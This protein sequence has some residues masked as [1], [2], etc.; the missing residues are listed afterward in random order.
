MNKELLKE[1]FHFTKNG[2]ETIIIGIILV[3]QLIIYT[4]SYPFIMKEIVDKAIPEGNMKIVVILSFILIAIIL[5]RFITNSYT[6]VRRKSC[7]YNNDNEIKEKLFKNIQESKISKIEQLQIGKLFEVV[8]NQSYEASQLFVWNFVGIISVRLALTIAISI[9]LLLLNMKLGLIVIS[10]F[11]LSYCILIPIY[12]KTMKV[13]KKLQSM[14]I[15]LQASVNEYIDSYAT[16]KT[17]RLEEINLEQIQEMLEKAK[18]EMIIA[19]KIIAMHNGLFSILTFSATIAI[20][21]VGGNELLLGIG[22]SSTIMLMIDYVDDINRHMKSLLEHVH[23][24]NNRYTCFINVLKISKIEKEVDNENKNLENINNIEFKNVSLSYDGI[25]IVLE[26]INFKV[27]KPMQI[28]IVGKSGTGK[29]SLINLLPRFYEINSGN[30]LINGIDSREYKLEELRKNIAYVF[31]EPV[32]F[33]KSISDNIRYGNKNNISQE[34]IEKV[35]KQIGLD[36]KIYELPNGYD[37][38]ISAK[39]DLLSYGE[40]QLLSFARAI[41]KQADLILLDEVTSNLDLEFEENVMEAMKEMLQNKISFVIA[42]RLNTI[43]NSDLILFL[44]DKHIIEAGTHEELMQ[45]KG[46]YYELYSSKKDKVTI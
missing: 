27:E 40:K 32:I 31:Q 33:E 30:I 3:L 14:L 29:T 43:K 7:C 1:M 24:L 25:N 21:I 35:C 39:T 18:K 17:L 46:K 16:T 28:A 26:N 41:L 6:E 19:S 15:D 11:V 22:S 37:C 42:H 4:F 23:S 12:A 5:L 34:Q 13:Y 20:M 9:I 36:K 10:I 2:K 44:E 38:I 45:A 8:F